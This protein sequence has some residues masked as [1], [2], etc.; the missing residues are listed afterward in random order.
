MNFNFT[1]FGNRLWL[2]GRDIITKGPYV[3]CG[4][5]NRVACWP[6]DKGRCYTSCGWRN[7]IDPAHIP[8]GPHRSRH[9]LD[10]PF[11]DQPYRK[12]RLL[13]G[14]WTLPSPKTSSEQWSWQWWWWAHPWC[15]S[16]WIS[17]NTLSN[18][19][20]VQSGSEKGLFRP[21][22]WYGKE[23]GKVLLLHEAPDEPTN[24]RQEHQGAGA[25]PQNQRLPCVF[26]KD[27]LPSRD[28]TR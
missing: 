3:H 12:W 7:C 14:V 20:W 28:W 15:A 11:P 1:I 16:R 13:G 27:M 23:N 10:H 6:W 8:Q 2:A 17:C 4:L 18:G 19:L 24:T 5:C 22:L 9:A 25:L 26:S 21:R